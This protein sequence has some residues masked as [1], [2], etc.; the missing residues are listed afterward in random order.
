MTLSARAADTHVC[1]TI[2]YMAFVPISVV[3]AAIAWIIFFF[4]IKIFIAFLP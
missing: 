4:S 3:A 1:A 2:F